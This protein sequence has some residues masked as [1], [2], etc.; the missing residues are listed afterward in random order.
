MVD[1]AMDIYK[2]L[3]NTEDVPQGMIDRRVDVVARLKRLEE[4]AVPLINFLQNP[5]MTNEFKPD[6]QYNLQMLQ[7]RYQYAKFQFEC[8]NYSGAADFLYQYRA[9]CTNSDRNLS[10]IWGK[11]ATEILMQY[12]D[13]ALGE[14]NHLREIID[15]KLMEEEVEVSVA[16]EPVKMDTEESKSDAAPVGSDVNM[17]D[18]KNSEDASGADNGVPES[19][20]KPVQMETDTKSICISNYTNQISFRFKISTFNWVYLANSTCF[21]W[22]VVCCLYVSKLNDKYFEFVTQTEREELITKLQEVEDWLYEDG[23][24]ETKVLGVTLS[25]HRNLAHRSYKIISNTCLLI[26]LFTHIKYN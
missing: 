15:A 14:L 3:Y 11:L 26:S 8:G 19:G 5:N 23:E 17:E 2:S 9:L 25:Y 18:A 20:D 22:R 4:S 1:Y 13:V 21:L 7:E 16:K 6:K 24:D 10:A 12:W